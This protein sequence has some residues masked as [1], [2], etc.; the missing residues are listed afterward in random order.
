MFGL[1]VT[2]HHIRWLHDPRGER[3]SGAPI[4]V[5]GNP[6]NRAHGVPRYLQGLLGSVSGQPFRV[7]ELSRRLK[8]LLFHMD[9]VTERIG[10]ELQTLGTYDE[11]RTGSITSTGGTSAHLASRVETRW[12]IWFRAYSEL[13]QD[14]L[15]VG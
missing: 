5:N 9:W 13:L 10:A 15:D 12:T 14:V 1:A 7:V 3:D 11:T 8:V 2:T 4:L 6:S